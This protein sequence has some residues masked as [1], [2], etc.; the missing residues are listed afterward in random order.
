MTINKFLQE[1]YVLVYKCL[2]S[3]LTSKTRVEPDLY[4]MTNGHV[5]CINPN[6]GNNFKTTTIV[7]T[8]GEQHI[9]GQ[10]PV[11]NVVGIH[12][13]ASVE[14]PVEYATDYVNNQN[15]LS[16]INSERGCP[17]IDGCADYGDHHILTDNAGLP[18]RNQNYVNHPGV[19]GGVAAGVPIDPNGYITNGNMRIP[20]EGMESTCA[21]IPQ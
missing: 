2:E 14:M 17:T 11:K 19:V 8:V 9:V 15:H 6:D 7:P 21:I 13:Y 5:N 10:L 18:V 3:V 12:E 4:T 20:P 1:D 16:H